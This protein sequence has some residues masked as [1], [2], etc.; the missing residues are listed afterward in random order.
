M[1][2]LT[3][4]QRASSTTSMQPISHHRGKNVQDLDQ[5]QLEVVPLAS[6]ATGTATGSGSHG[7][8][9]SVVVVNVTRND[10]FTLLTV[11]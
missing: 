4:K 5:D 7:G 6:S 2:M 8:S 1:V 9:V 3:T 11:I 10:R